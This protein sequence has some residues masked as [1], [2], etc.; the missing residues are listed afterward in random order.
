MAN[1]RAG[2]QSYNRRQQT[3]HAVSTD[4]LCQLLA[5][6]HNSGLNFPLWVGTEEQILARSVCLQ[7]WGRHGGAHRAGLLS[8]LPDL[9]FRGGLGDAPDKHLC[10]ERVLLD[11]REGAAWCDN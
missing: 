7:G 10:E 3:L 5:L 9:L 4:F 8:K 11:F 2:S 6:V 1:R